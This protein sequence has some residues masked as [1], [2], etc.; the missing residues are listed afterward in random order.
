MEVSWKLSSRFRKFGV[1]R[2][3]FLPGLLLQGMTTKEPD[4]RQLEVSIAALKALL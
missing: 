1:V 4:D 3:L 2:L